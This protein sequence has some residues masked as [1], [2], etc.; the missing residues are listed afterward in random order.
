VPSSHPPVGLPRR[1]V[2]TAEVAFLAWRERRVPY[3]SPES[4]ERRQRRRLRA[5]VRHGYETTRFWREALDARGIDPRDVRSVEDLAR[6]PR[7]DGRTVR[8][9]LTAFRSSRIPD[10][11]THDLSSSGSTD[12][13]IRKVVPWDHR[14]QLLKIARSVR[15][16]DA[17]EAIAG[18]G[19]ARREAYLMPRRS[20]SRSV[21]AF[22]DARL[23]TRGL[24][25]ERTW[26]PAELPFEEAVR[27]LLE[28]RPTVVYS[29]GSHSERFLGRVLDRGVELPP[30]HVWIYGG[31]M[32]PAPRREAIER[33][34][35]FPITTTYQTVEAG[36][37]GFE[38]EARE[39]LHVHTDLVAVRILD[40]GG[41]DVRRGEV[42][43]VVV[44]NLVNRATVLI[45]VRLGDRA[46]W[47]EGPC[48]CGRTLPRLGGLQGRVSEIV[49][50]A[51]GREWSVIVLRNEL[52]D[53][54]SFALQVQVVQPRDD[55][56]IWR[57][58]PLESA[59]ARNGA[60]GLERDSRALFGPGTRV[61][62]RLVDRLPGT[63]AGKVPAVVRSG[64]GR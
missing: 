40:P 6:L 1:L 13:G 50:A 27:R 3:A 30:L 12:Q 20:A 42:G 25:R 61:E 57:I 51:D 56:V 38:C 64:R 22:W 54:L 48:P 63:E 32:F 16:R 47:I 62:V 49:R 46:A 18:P 37:I 43:E 55:H 35:G 19:W 7:V 29:Y 2:N 58:A 11:E 15:D 36:R 26:I 41:G 39:G 8:T 21:R 4:I 52:A 5:T 53:A 9:R 10:G 14:S 23:V 33:E 24:R 59:D 17:V 28:A 31:D 44:T 34:V 45:N 60:R